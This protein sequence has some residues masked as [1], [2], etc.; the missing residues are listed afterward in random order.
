MQNRVN[1]FQKYLAYP[2][3]SSNSGDINKPESKS[4][5]S[6]KWRGSLPTTR[7]LLRKAN[8]ADLSKALL[9]FSHDL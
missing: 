5:Y 2:N 8:Q 1:L 9:A 3:I 7:M 6:W 4:H